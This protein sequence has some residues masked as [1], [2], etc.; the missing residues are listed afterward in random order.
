MHIVSFYDLI[1]PNTAE[2]VTLRHWQ[3][4]I[5]IC[6]FLGSGRPTYVRTTVISYSAEAE[7]RTTARKVT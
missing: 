7:V 6:H 3:I 1:L 5:L 2:K 4:G